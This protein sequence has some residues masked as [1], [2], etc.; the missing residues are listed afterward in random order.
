MDEEKKSG[1][2]SPPQLGRRGDGKE[3]TVEVVLDEVTADVV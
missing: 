2:R 3:A 1:N